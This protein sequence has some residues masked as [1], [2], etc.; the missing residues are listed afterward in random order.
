MVGMIGSKKN[1][2]RYIA[3]AAAAAALLAGFLFAAPQSGAP[4]ITLDYEFFKS[5]VEP[6]YLKQRSPDHARCIACHVKTKHP[7][8]LSLEPL[9]PG[10]HSWTEEQSRRNFQTVL[11]LVVPGN[12]DA[13]MFPMHPL[14]P[15]AGGDSVTPHS[16][17][18][19]FESQ[20]DP[21]FQTI[22]EWIH[23]KK[24]DASTSQ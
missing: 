3:I 24:A 11:K 7:R 22:V 18:R 6:I 20:N 23:G 12:V 5:R 14:A 16:G 10:S 15:E 19:Q 4:K 9:S 2:A 1:A 17:G 13:S 8:G 21:D